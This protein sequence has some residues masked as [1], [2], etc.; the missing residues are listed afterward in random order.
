MKV[1]IEIDGM[2][3]REVMNL[4]YSLYQS[5]DVEGRPSAKTRGGQFSVSVKSL[6]NGN[7][8]LFEWACE[9]HLKKNGKIDFL[10]RDGTNMKTLE[11]EEAYLVSFNESYDANDASSQF[12]NIVMSA[13]KIDIGGI[14]HENDW[15]D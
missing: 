5:T 9:S 13:K 8:E 2:E 10:N 15:A 11:F 14:Y 4:S 6:D 7:V 12:E 3:I 1:I